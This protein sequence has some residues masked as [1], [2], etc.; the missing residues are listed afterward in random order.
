MFAGTGKSEFLAQGLT[1]AIDEAGGG[2][3]FGTAIDIKQVGA[4]V[5]VVGGYR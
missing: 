2:E 5:I 4:I 1:F 3:E